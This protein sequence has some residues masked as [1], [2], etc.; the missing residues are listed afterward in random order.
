[1]RRPSPLTPKGLDCVPAPKKT[2][3]FIIYFQQIFK[4][5]WG[6]GILAVKEPDL[7]HIILSLGAFPDILAEEYCSVAE[8]LYKCDVIDND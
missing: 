5:F 3:Y 4:G 8:I 1:M 6:F 7:S 2:L